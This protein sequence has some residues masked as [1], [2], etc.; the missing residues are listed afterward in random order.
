VTGDDVS[1]LLDGM[2]VLDVS[3][4]RPVPHATQLLADLGAEVLKVEPP[5]GDPMRGFPELFADIASHK[6]SVICDL[7]TEAG[8]ERVLELAADADVFCEGWRPGVADRL[9]LGYDAI[10]ARNPSIVY[11]SLSGYGQTGPFL[12]LRGHDLNYQA[13]AGAVAPR[14]SD[15]A[16]PSIPRVP[17]AD[18]AGG[19]V[20]AL[21]IC[22][23]WARRLQT[24]EGEYIDVSMT[25]VIASWVGPRSGTAMAGRTEVTRGSTGYG[26]Y[27]CADGRYL[28]LATISEDHFW[29]ATCDALDLP[30]F[31]D[32][33]HHDRLDRYQECDAAI[34]DA[35]KQLARDEAV[36]RLAAAGAPVAP[37]LEPE[38]AGR[39][40]NFHARGVFAADAAGETRVAFP[41][42]LREHPARPPGPR[43]DPGEHPEGW[44]GS[45]RA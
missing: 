41:A 12:E 34:V 44:S 10:R 43:P 4:W 15:V 45:S 19:T 32:L 35:C 11:C 31:R 42:R 7:K 21:C 36:E 28:T 6:R 38:E 22:A 24:G 25:D 23:A 5:G 33:G 40:P 1:G 20:A 30:Q 16:P 3:I 27:V 13:L 17:I 29:R 8:H 18:L 14:P 9:G 2:R 26:V 37:V 39:H